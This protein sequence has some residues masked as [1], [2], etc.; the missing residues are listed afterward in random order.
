MTGSKGFKVGV[1]LALGN[2]KLGVGTT[3]TEV[4]GS[5]TGPADNMNGTTLG[6]SGAAGMAAC[7]G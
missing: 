3:M 5:S 1:P 7:Q 6:I 2:G 4:V